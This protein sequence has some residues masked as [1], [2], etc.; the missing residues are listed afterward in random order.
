M[1]F[2]HEKFKAALRTSDL[3]WKNR[4]PVFPN[5]A[6]ED[7][8]LIVVNKGYGP[9]IRFVEPDEASQGEAE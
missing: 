7:K 8:R 9:R 4:P 5:H 6:S 1:K 3:Y 2:T